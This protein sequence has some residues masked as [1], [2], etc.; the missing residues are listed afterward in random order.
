MINTD[1]NSA[2]VRGFLAY[3][4]PLPDSLYSLSSRSHFDIDDDLL[5]TVEIVGSSKESYLQNRT[6]LL[7]E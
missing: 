5:E 3:R 4:N 2:I 7:N 1:E 6:T